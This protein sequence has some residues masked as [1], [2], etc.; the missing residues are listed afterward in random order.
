[1]GLNRFLREA[2]AARLD[3][4]RIFFIRE[5]SY[6]DWDNYFP[7]GELIELT[8]DGREA[9]PYR[10]M[11]GGVRMGWSAEKDIYDVEILSMEKFGRKNIKVFLG[12]GTN[13][14]F[15]GLS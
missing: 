8:P 10:F 7:K 4:S 1:M 11:V 6:A 12:R 13:G 2:L 15:S 5:N 14:G 9:D 3:F